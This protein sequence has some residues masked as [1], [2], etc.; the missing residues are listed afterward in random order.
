ML[1]CQKQTVVL[2]LGTIFIH[3]SSTLSQVTETCLAPPREPVINY[4]EQNPSFVW[5]DPTRDPASSRVGSGHARLAKPRQ[6]DVKLCTAIN[7][8]LAQA[9]LKGRY[10]H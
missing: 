5:P 9:R 3:I 4:G 2:M 8:S 6:S 1:H 7:Y 10:S